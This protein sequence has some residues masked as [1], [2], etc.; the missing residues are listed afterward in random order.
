MVRLG[1]SASTRKRMQ[2]L[3]RII[4]S[5]FGC[6]LPWCTSGQ[7]ERSTTRLLDLRPG[8]APVVPGMEDLQRWEQPSLSLAD[9][10]RLLV[11]YNALMDRLAETNGHNLHWWATDLASKNRF[12]SPLAAR[13]N[14]LYSCTQALQALKAADSSWRTL[15]ILGADQPQ[16]RFL[17]SQADSALKIRASRLFGLFSRIAGNAQTLCR[18]ARAALAWTCRISLCRHL[19]GLH[20]P[21]TGDRPLRM[22]KSFAYPNSFTPQGDFKDPF[23]PELAE[24]L[25]IASEQISL[26]TL[27]IVQCLTYPIKCYKGLRKQR[28][29]VPLEAYLSLTD[30]LRAIAELWGGR[31]RNPFRMPTPLFFDGV[32]ISSFV[33]GSIACGGWH[34]PLEQYLHNIAGRR[35]AER[36]KLQSCLITY[37]GNPWE[38]M[39]V[40]GLRVGSP[41][42]QVQGCQHAAPPPAAAGIFPG[43]AECRLAPLPDRILCTGPRVA[44][45][46]ARNSALSS[47]RVHSACALRFGALEKM[48]FHALPKGSPSLLVALEGVPEVAPMLNYVLDEA[49]KMPDVP[50]RI[51]AHPAMPFPRFAAI[52]SKPKLPD[53]VTVSQGSTLLEDI[54]GANVVLYWGSTVAAEAL[55]MGRPIIH[56]DRGD[57]LSYDFLFDLQF[58]KLTVRQGTSLAEAFSNLSGLDATILR[59]AQ[60][61]VR[62]MFNSCDRYDTSMFFAT[63]VAH[64]SRKQ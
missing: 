55:L 4:P 25:E 37:E 8:P 62:G 13:L 31:L 24:K 41:G 43:N 27:T 59:K 44:D 52:L 51:R 56:F 3:I 21:D 64:D 61:Y 36:H 40:S 22:I 63:E 32:D 58:G 12:T 39:L 33:K 14:G 29:V 15:V 28:N 18:M 48:V 45:L 1:G 9:Q 16:I 60:E 5:L 11:Q 17:L 20:A 53:N 46:I 2:K 38:R 26:E 34:M 35:I 23:F 10:Q 49:A 19:L 7:F 50:I 47:E 42:L 6:I 57:I 54:G 30:P